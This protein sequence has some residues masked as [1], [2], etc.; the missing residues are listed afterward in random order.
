MG[1]SMEGIK[2]DAVFEF[3][4]LEPDSIFWD[5][6]APNAECIHWLGK[7]MEAASRAEGRVRNY[8]GF[9][10]ARARDIREFR[11]A[12]GF[13]FSIAH[14]PREGLHHVHISFRSEDGVTPNKPQ[15]AELRVALVQR[16]FTEHVSAP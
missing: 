7:R 2:V 13:G 1:D 5:R 12:A 3:P 16:I 15:R 6:F 9:L 11:S 8:I 14:A 10:N 4:K